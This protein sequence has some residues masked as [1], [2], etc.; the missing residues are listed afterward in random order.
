MTRLVSLSGKVSRLSEESARAPTRRSRPGDDSAERRLNF[1][2]GDRPAFF[3]GY[4]VVGE[5]D[6]VTIAGFEAGG[7]LKALAIR[8]RST[9]VDYGGASP[10]LYLLCGSAIL[11]GAFTVTIGGLGLL[12]LALAAWL[13][14]RLYRKARALSLVRAATPVR[15]EKGPV[16]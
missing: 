6:L 10:G 4:P 2:V 14:N 5:G 9:G 1:L 15:A 8:N 3:R 13:G 16:R 7:I 12:F 11:L